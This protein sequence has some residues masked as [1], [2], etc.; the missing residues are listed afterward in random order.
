MKERIGDLFIALG[1]ADPL[2]LLTFVGL[3]LALSFFWA[4]L[5]SSWHTAVRVGV[6]I[7]GQVLALWVAYRTSD[8]WLVYLIL[9]TAPSVMVGLF[10]G[11]LS[12]S[13][14]AHNK[15]TVK[16]DTTSGSIGVDIREH[17]SI[18]GATGAGKTDSIY[19]PI[20][21]HVFSHG[22]SSVIF[23]YKEFELME[24]VYFFE[25]QAREE[26]LKRAIAGKKTVKVPVVHA[27]YPNDPNYSVWINFISPDY[28]QQMEDAESVANTLF[29]NLYPG[30]GAA[31]GNFFR[32]T[33]AGAFAGTVW[34]FKEDFPERCSF[35]YV[36]AMIIEASAD[37]LIAFVSQNPKAKILA[38]PFVDSQGN[39]KQL[40][41]VKSSITAAIKK[42][43]TP[44]LFM[45]FSRNEIDIRVNEP[46]K[47]IVLGLVNTPSKDAVYLPLIATI[48]RLIIDKCSVRGRDYSIWV[49]DEASALKFKMLYRVLAIM[50]TFK[51]L[52]AW[53]LQDKVQGEL[54][55]NVKE[56]KAI[57]SN[58][59][60]QFMGKANDP[61]TAEFYT[62]LFET[63][64]VEERSYS[65]GDGRSSITKSTR[66]KKKYK[67]IEFR[68]LSAGEFFLVDKQ[69]KDR[70]VKFKETR[71]QPVQAPRTH[72]MSK[73]EIETHFDMVFQTVRGMVQEIDLPETE[74]EGL[75]RE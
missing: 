46:G 43:C 45:V 14:V 29:D 44:N 67:P 22:L 68:R 27:L 16:M 62:R 5:F 38:A 28:I 2:V 66:E 3:V 13:S 6:V 74:G 41:S 26:N 40:A 21:Q 20:I 30:D 61:D 36:C 47:E 25:Q 75:Y 33:A 39:R 15:Y 69:G 65:S 58:M 8:P 34:R 11:W 24:K 71:Y 10:I 7:T 72:N 4:T 1:Q 51:I 59:G 64:D 73:V 37:Q 57:T 53:G 50:R 17:V 31:D 54:L 49:L 23:D 55:Y 32:E 18:A 70:K 63:V 56:L 12:S 9:F 48:S 52:V 42:L 60:L 35:P 19:L